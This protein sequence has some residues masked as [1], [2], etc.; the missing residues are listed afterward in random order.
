MTDWTS[1]LGYALGYVVAFGWLVLPIVVLLLV[2]RTRWFK[3]RHRIRWAGE[4]IV[5][6]SL[7]DPMAE[8]GPLGEDPQVR[9]S[10][11]RD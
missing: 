10:R 3:R 6:E 2:V 5:P 8:L 9:G 11:R 4:R 7:I 1:A